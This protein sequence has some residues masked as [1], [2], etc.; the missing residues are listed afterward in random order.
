MVYILFERYTMRAL[1]IWSIRG[2]AL[3]VFAL[4]IHVSREIY[5]PVGA[6]VFDLVVGSI[7]FGTLTLF[8][9]FRRNVARA[10]FLRETNIH[11]TQF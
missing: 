4:M 6:I 9:R 10:K 1:M 2:L 5:S 7:L 3:F 8:D 11:A